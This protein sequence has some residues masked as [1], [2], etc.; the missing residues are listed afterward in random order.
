[1]HQQ[2]DWEN[3]AVLQ[4]K[5]LPEHAWFFSYDS[6]SRALTYQREASSIKLLN[7]RWKFYYADSPYE[8]PAHFYEQDYD[9]SHW[10]DIP[11]PSSWQM[12][13]Y[14]RPHYTNVQYPFPVDPPHI[15][16]ENPTGCYRR[17]FVVPESWTERKIVLRF[18]GVDSAFHVW[19]NGHKAGYSQGSRTGS[20]FN[21]TSLV[22]K[23]ENTIAVRVYQWSD[24]SYIEDQDM[25]WLS[26]IFRDVYLIA[27][28]QTSVQ[29]VFI[30]A[31]LDENY[32]NGVLDIET[33]ID[34]LVPGL[35]LEVLL[36]DQQHKE[37]AKRSTAANDA[38]LNVSLPVVHP[39]K[40]SAES[41][42]LYHLLLILKDK[43]GEVVEAIPNKVGFRTVELKDGVMLVNGV[44]IMLKGVNRHDHHP[45]YGKAVP[46]NWMLEDVKLMKQ[47]NINAV[48]TS[49]YP[50][51][52]RFYDLCDE[53]GLYVIDEADLECHGFEIT[54][55]IHQISDEPAWE[56][57][58]VDRM[59]RMV[60]RD[61]N[62]PSIIMWS[63]GNESGFGR[64]HVAMA[65]WA[66]QRDPSRL[67]HYEGEL[68][69]MM[70][71][72]DRRVEPE[73]DPKVS[74][75]HTTMYTSVE[76]M[77]RLGA[78]TDFKKPHIMCE[79]AHAMG[80]GPGNLKEYWEVFYKHKR[81]QGGFVWEW[82]DHGI[83]QKT[84]DG[85][86]YYAYGGDF[87]DEPNDSN[88]VIDGLVRPD[89]TP[90]PGLLEYKKVIQPVC[91]KAVDLANGKVVI[92]NRY[93]FIDLAHLRATWSVEVDGRV[94]ESGMQDVP[95]LTAGESAVCTVPYHLPEEIPSLSDCLL[96]ITFTL[97]GE[98]KWAPAGHE[99]AWEQFVLPAK[100]KVVTAVQ[101]TGSGSIRLEETPTQFIAEGDVFKVVFNK[102]YGVMET[103]SYQGY[104][105]LNQGPQLNLWR[106]PIDN[107][108]RS[109]PMWKKH[110]LHQ[111]QHRVK[112][113][114]CVQHHDRIEFIAHIRT[115]PP[116]LAWGIEI[117]YHY[118]VYGNGEIAIK[119]DGVPVGDFPETFPRIGLALTLP[120][121]FDGVSWSGKGPGEAYVDSQEAVRY[122]VWSMKVADLYTPYVY[123]Q[124]NGNR[125]DV[126]WAALTNESGVGLKVVGDPRF[127]FSAHFYTTTDFDQARHTCDLRKRDFITLNLDHKQH[128][129][130]SASC[131]PDVLGE[132]Q[133]K[134]EPFS[135]GFVLNPMVSG[136]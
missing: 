70:W 82:L 34:N 111:M 33:T 63:L 91:V 31:K 102:I 20:A 99:V 22:T 36:L 123:P 93:D 45:V 16:T 2:P 24:G 66:K 126:I 64:N 110:G 118:T 12:Q 75:V 68:D 26:G 100:R 96:N 44:P 106:A 3:L 71:R 49:H 41:P 101:H 92:H 125:H 134:V 14:G 136:E 53:Y 13:G 27:K 84:D 115:A 76:M 73:K 29:D 61:K 124:E 114:D 21:I 23:G 39:K 11:V 135:F 81:L 8:A 32:E 9:T 55:N 62:H 57:A 4:R 77:D 59:Q 6:V 86:T 128:G 40:W 127:D 88:F 105:L 48:R 104:H 58:Y 107:D 19:I 25:W 80:N 38:T 7:G 52:P 28:P 98:T 103:W 129:L 67:I 87:G 132:Y 121:D 37:I 89:H 10:E 109:V 72:E 131:G 43:A 46:L 79:Y 120:T 83:L 122:G 56:A 5:R 97:A 42:Y 74:D 50:N 94:L 30:Q 69:K 54:G 113:V 117:S 116:V 51:D 85:E 15:P 130:G 78:R 133:L 17:T 119:V 47:H 112:A 95:E 60:E 35:T 90:S 108:H 18:E 1:M 65:E